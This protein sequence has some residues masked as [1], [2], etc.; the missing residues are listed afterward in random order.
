[1]AREGAVMWKV[2][3]SDRHWWPHKP[4]HHIKYVIFFV[5][6]E[7]QSYAGVF[8]KPNEEIQLMS[9]LT[10][11]HTD[12]LTLVFV[13]ADGNP[14]IPQPTPDASPAAIWLNS[15]SS[16]SPDTFSVSPDASTATVSATAAG[17]DDIS[18]AVSVGGQV[19]SASLHL[20]I[21]AAPQVLSGVK[22]V[23]SVA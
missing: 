18:V 12:T 16:P 6:H 10:V 7:D 23:E 9:K 17:A 20:D 11:G 13:D 2:K 21:S 22:I 8:L 15:P 1:M 3:H 19:F 5:L 4:H 14:M